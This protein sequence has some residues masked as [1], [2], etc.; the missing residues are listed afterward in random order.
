MQS[1]SVMLEV[2]K[3]V[4]MIRDLFLLQLQ[5]RVWFDRLKFLY[6]SIFHFINKLR[7]IKLDKAVSKFHFSGLTNLC[8]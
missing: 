2:S 6:S 4:G 1:T 5:F 7:S 8:F 3:N